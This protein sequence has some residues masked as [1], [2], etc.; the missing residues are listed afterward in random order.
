MTDDAVASEPKEH[1]YE[2]LSL[3]QA[4]LVALLGTVVIVVLAFLMYWNHPNRKYDLARPGSKEDNNALEVTDEQAD[5]TSPVDEAAAK[6]KLEYLNSELK[7]LE[8]LGE[9]SPED[10]SDENIQLAPTQQPSL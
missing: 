4:L 2:R 10:L 6:Q 3:I 8:G 1:W 9:F 7:A 5:T